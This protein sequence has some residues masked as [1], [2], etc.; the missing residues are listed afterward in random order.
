MDPSSTTIDY[1]D[2]LARSNCG[3]LFEKAVPHGRL[4]REFISVAA[5]D[6]SRLSMSTQG[7]SS[8]PVEIPREIFD[9]FLAANYIEQYCPEDSDGRILFR[10]TGDGLRVQEL[11]K[12]RDA[13]STSREIIAQLVVQFPSSQLGKQLLAGF[14]A[15]IAALENTNSESLVNCT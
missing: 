15:Q 12:K 4:K 7:F 14:D 10:L 1:L 13:L 5:S 9:Y 6:R 11:A 8:C 3:I 2:L